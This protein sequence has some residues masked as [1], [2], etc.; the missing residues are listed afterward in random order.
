MPTY[1]LF[2]Y[3]SCQKCEEVK[4]FLK[5]T[6]L[7]G[8]ELDLSLKDGKQRIREYISLIRRD[9]KGGMV[10]PVLVLKDED[11][12]QAVLHSREEVEAWLRSKA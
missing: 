7:E 4:A 2:T 9:D 6:P 10:L 5:T 1:E 8:R 11:G 12:V 3:P